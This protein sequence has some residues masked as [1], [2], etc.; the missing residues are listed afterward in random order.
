M[1][2]K[3]CYYHISMHYLLF[4]SSNNNNWMTH[5]KQLRK[6]TGKNW[7]ILLMLRIEIYKSYKYNTLRIF[8][9][10]QMRYYQDKIFRFLKLHPFQ[11]AVS[12]FACIKYALR[13]F[14]ISAPCSLNLRN[15][16]LKSACHCRRTIWFSLSPYSSE[17]EKWL[18]C[19]SV[20]GSAEVF[21]LVIGIGIRSI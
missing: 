18:S 11:N 17:L 19:L 8:Y 12:V 13:V 16:N 4:V 15:F 5:Q 21:D 3:L 20:S 2:R 6:A 10:I 7:F 14:S 9:Y 1:I